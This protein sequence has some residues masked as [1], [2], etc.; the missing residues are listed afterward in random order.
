MNAATPTNS[1]IASSTKGAAR[2]AHGEVRPPLRAAGL[3]PDLGAV[4]LLIVHDGL[5]PGG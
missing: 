1:G 2:Q 3:P 5:P 4:V